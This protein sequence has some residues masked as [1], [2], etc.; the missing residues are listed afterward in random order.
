MYGTFKVNNESDK[1]KLTLGNYS[2]TAGDGLEYHNG[3]FFS[4][5]D[6]DNDDEERS[7]YAQ[8][9]KGAWWYEFY[10]DSN[11]NG[12]YLGNKM[13]LKGIGWFPWKYIELSLKGSVMK[14]RPPSSN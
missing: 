1:Y 2:G 6:K 13:D 10:P 3:M 8:D 4:T 12:L 7:N 9:Y 11:L 5:K 14:T